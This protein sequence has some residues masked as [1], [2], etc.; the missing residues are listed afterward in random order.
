MIKCSFCSTEYGKGTLLVCSPRNDTHICRGCL[1]KC[2]DILEHGVLAMDK[3][4]PLIPIE[5]KGTM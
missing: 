2:T 5:N 1:S 4:I 3:V